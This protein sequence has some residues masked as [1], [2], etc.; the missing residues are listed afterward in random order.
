MMIEIIDVT[1]PDAVRTA[2]I[3]VLVLSRVLKPPFGFE[4]FPPN[5][6]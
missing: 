1:S 6:K 4:S 5:A 2:V 3:G